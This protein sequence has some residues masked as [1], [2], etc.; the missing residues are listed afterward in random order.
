MDPP[1]TFYQVYGA[2]AVRD[3]SPIKN[4]IKKEW[5]VPM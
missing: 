2:L 4:G 5:C 3:D 1:L